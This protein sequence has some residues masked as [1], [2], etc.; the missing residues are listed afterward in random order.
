M[1]SAALPGRSDIRAILSSGIP[2]PTIFGMLWQSLIEVKSMN[3]FKYYC[4]YQIGG[5]GTNQ[6]VRWEGGDEKN[7]YFSSGCKA[8]TNSDFAIQCKPVEN[9]TGSGYVSEGSD[10]T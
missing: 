1:G 2:S 10:P 6:I 4:K 3:D 7:R 9:R 5:L 8:S